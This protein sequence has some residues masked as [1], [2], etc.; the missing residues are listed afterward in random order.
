M[1]EDHISSGLSSFTPHDVK[2]P[3]EPVVV[4]PTPQV[5]PATLPQNGPTPE[6]VRQMALAAQ[7]AQQEQ[8]IID[9][10]ERKKR[11][12]LQKVADARRPQVNPQVPQP[13]SPRILEQTRREMAEGA[14]QNEIHAERTR[15]GPIPPRPDV[16]ST[17]VHRPADWV[18]NMNQGQNGAR[19]V[20]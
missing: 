9:E 19:N 2:V 8:A 10:R 13:V 16:Q 5:D 6:E 4:A 14:R 11:E 17:P 15:S 12:F 1:S 20:G 3:Q 7:R 18:P